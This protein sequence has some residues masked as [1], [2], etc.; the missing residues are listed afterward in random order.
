MEILKKYTAVILIVLPLLILVLIRSAGSNH[1][2]PDAEKL[3][4]PSFV[5]SNIINVDKLSSLPGDKLIIN[6]SEQEENI[7]NVL[8]NVIKIA[9]GDI[10]L[11]DN[12]NKIKENAGE[13]VLLY[14]PDV[15]MVSRIWMVLTQMGIK[16]TF[17]LTTDS[18]N[19]LIKHEFRPDT[20]LKPEFSEY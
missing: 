19:E 7:K 11:K 8:G 9:P 17:I 12:I 5:K 1:F 14:S 15:A 18:D 20:L 10:L 16:N 2:K 4:E 3:A 13:P 6:L